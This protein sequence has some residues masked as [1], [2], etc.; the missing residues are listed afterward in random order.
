MTVVPQKRYID[1]LVTCGW[2]RW[3]W[4]ENLIY[5]ARICFS[6][7][8][9]SRTGALN[10]EQ[11]YLLGLTT[12]RSA[13]EPPWRLLTEALDAEVVF[14]SIASRENV[15]RC[16]KIIREGT[17][18]VRRGNSVEGGGDW[19]W[20]VSNVEV[21]PLRSRLI[22][23]QKFDEDV[24]SAYAR[25][26]QSKR[27]DEGLH[28]L[29]QTLLSNGDELRTAFE[30]AI[31]YATRAKLLELCRT[32]ETVKESGGGPKF[33][34]APEITP[35]TPPAPTIDFNACKTV[36]D[37]LGDSFAG[38]LLTLEQ[39]YFTFGLR[40]NDLGHITNGLQEL[41]TEARTHY[42]TMG[43]SAGTL[44]ALELIQTIVEAKVNAAGSQ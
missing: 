22:G 26:R 11:P 24:R 29:H 33:A 32:V 38:T 12:T 2:D 8:M 9:N 39:F 1:M 42:D 34:G 15:A 30:K 37:V 7:R 10:V 31:T 35:H 43:R 19:F 6:D 36:R 41:R 21:V 16:K 20:K 40:L 5:K 17:Q 3:G 25:V 44:I 4:F 23:S 13:T 14:A 27:S 28:L 18:E